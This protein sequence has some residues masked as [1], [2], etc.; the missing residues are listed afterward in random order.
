MKIEEERKA[1]EKAI[2]EICKGVDIKNNINHD[3]GEY[4][5]GVCKLC[6]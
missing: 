2:K 4:L 5:Y 6:G 1:F 3:T